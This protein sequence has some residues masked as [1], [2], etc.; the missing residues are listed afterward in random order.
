MYERHPLDQ[1]NYGPSPSAELRED[2]TYLRA[3]VEVL[4]P[5]DQDFAKSLLESFDGPRGCSS[6]Q[7]HWISVLAQRAREVRNAPAKVQIDLTRINQMID[8]AGKKLKHPKLLVRDAETG[9]IYRVTP[10][11][12]G[13]RYYGQLN[14]T[15]TGSYEDR[16]WYGRLDQQGVFHA[17]PEARG[18]FTAIERALQALAQDPAGVAK[19]YGQATGVCCFCGI[20][21]TDERSVSA[22]YGPICAEN[23]GLAWGEVNPRK[24]KSVTE[25]QATQAL[26]GADFAKL[27]Q[28]VVAALATRVE[29]AGFQ[30]DCF[31]QGDDPIC[32]PVEGQH[33]AAS[34]EKHI[35]AAKELFKAMPHATWETTSSGVVVSANAHLDKPLPELL[36]AYAKALLELERMAGCRAHDL[37]EQ[38]A[39]VG[40]ARWE[41]ED[42]AAKR[43]R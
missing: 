6:K 16:T 35:R 9:A 43:A 19:A 4:I 20:T 41:I 30:Y 24:V 23:F 17:S 3:N 8:R 26:V 39:I 32:I 40:R 11:G 42:W 36:D 7:A 29:Y 25:E 22:G 12:P 5:K 27:E 31:D 1:T 10:A 14:V 2:A 37:E 33:R 18:T 34:K 21:L 13:S 28:R 15:S 38:A